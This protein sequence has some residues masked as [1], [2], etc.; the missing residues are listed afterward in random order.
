MKIPQ[1]EINE[2]L[3]QIRK[4]GHYSDARLIHIENARKNRANYP[5]IFYIQ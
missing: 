1:W 4:V 3:S 5:S 2:N